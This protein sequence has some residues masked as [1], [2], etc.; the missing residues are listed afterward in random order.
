MLGHGDRAQG[1][2]TSFPPEAFSISPP[3]KAVQPQF[4]DGPS[5]P[6]ALFL[7]APA[8]SMFFGSCQGRSALPALSQPAVVFLALARGSRLPPYP[9]RALIRCMVM[10]A[11]HTYIGRVEGCRF[12]QTPGRIALRG[13]EHLQN[14]SSYRRPGAGKYD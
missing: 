11:P 10:S 9:P 12:A 5:D 13:R 3:L 2:W 7:L 1:K 4:E 6:H 14:E 8:S